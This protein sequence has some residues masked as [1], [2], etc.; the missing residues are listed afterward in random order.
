MSIFSIVFYSNKNFDSC[1]HRDKWRICI[2]FL[3]QLNG[4]PI[5]DNFPIFIGNNCRGSRRDK[6]DDRWDLADARAAMRYPTSSSSTATVRHRR[7]EAVQ[8]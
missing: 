2:G 5:E 3:S 4:Y 8:K 6:R 7:V 1:S